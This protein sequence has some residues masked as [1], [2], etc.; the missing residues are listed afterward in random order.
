VKA[1]AKGILREG[2]M[3]RS[4]QH[5]ASK[6]FSLVLVLA[7]AFPVSISAGERKIRGN[8]ATIHAR[9][10]TFKGTMLYID[11]ELLVL[12]EKKSG[13]LLGIAF[14]E[15]ERISIKKSKAGSGMLVGLGVGVILAT[16]LI[17]SVNNDQGNSGSANLFLPLIVAAVAVTGVLIAVLTTTAG[18][19]IGLLTGKK[20]FRLAKLSPE[21]KEAA[22]G[23]L[24]KYAVFQV[25]P[26]ELRS[27]IVMIAK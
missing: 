5:F 9:G 2:Q 23:R 16:L 12:K 15:V 11:R 7:L 14:P 27:K 21:K 1:E 19:L 4:K 26:D 25:L 6:A 22:L 13:A 3:A 18:G 24:K 17:A 8:K 10:A 20:N